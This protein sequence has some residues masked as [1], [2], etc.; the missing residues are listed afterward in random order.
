MSRFSRICGFSLCE[1][2]ACQKFAYVHPDNAPLVGDVR[3]SN[4]SLS[5]EIMKEALIPAM[6][7][8]I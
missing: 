6:V 2:I 8:N 7:Q 1:G 3:Q 5:E 4:S